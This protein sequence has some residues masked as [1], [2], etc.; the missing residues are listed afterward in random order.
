[1]VTS[2]RSLTTVLTGWGLER[3]AMV[4]IFSTTCALH[5]ALHVRHNCH[6]FCHRQRLPKLRHIP[7]QC[8][9]RYCMLSI[10]LN[11][12]GIQLICRKVP[13]FTQ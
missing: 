6:M 13:Q 5:A 7:C 8:P 1:M 9:D 4:L 10:S 12:G 2:G 3:K 11:C